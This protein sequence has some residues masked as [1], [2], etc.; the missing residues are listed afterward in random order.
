MPVIIIDFSINKLNNSLSEKRSTEEL[1][2]EKK[3]VFV[4]N[5]G[6]ICLIQI[7]KYK[8]LISSD[9][10]ETE[11]ENEKCEGGVS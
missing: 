4:E 3:S 1:K 10:S 9:V 2:R 7:S 6:I 11:L 8:M 5:N